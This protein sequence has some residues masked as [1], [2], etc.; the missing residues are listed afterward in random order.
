MKAL[1][2][3]GFIRGVCY[4]WSGDRS[5]VERDMG[6]AKRLALNSTRIWLSRTAFLRS[7]D[8]YVASLVS[9]V[10]TAHSFGLTTMPILWNGNM[11][12]PAILEEERRSECDDYV[13]R[14]VDALKEEEGLL[15]W[16]IMNEP[17]CNDYI[18]KAAGDEQQEREAKLWGFVRH[19]LEYVRSID[20]ENALTVGNTFIGDTGP[21]ADL[22]DV[23]SFHDYLET[24]SR[25][26]ATYLTAESL[27]RTFGKPLV[28]SELA[29][30]CRAN[31][32]DMA[33]EAC[34]R[35]NVGWYLFELMVH[36]Y[37]GDVHGIVYPDGTVRD[38]S[39]VAAIYGFRRNRDRKTSVRPNPNKEGHVY[40]A[41]ELVQSALRQDTT[42][43]RNKSNSTDEILEAAEYCA[44]LLEAAELVPMCEPPTMRI[45]QWRSQPE[46][47]RDV[48]A[49]RV[50][51]YDLAR[52][53]KEKTA[54]L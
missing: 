5:I 6:Y 11:L 28:N 21:T 46:E 42:L 15:M 40:R 9:Y 49:I 17:T 22:V 16:D 43:F 24:R 25:V 53:L 32:Y 35:H 33:L 14:I 51:A 44:N 45:L 7:P 38:P 36:G 2:D 29:C 31:P 18:R 3:Y 20:G 19:N 12:D 34:E 39:I 10:R 23:I 48:D 8:E 30:L 50:F 26:E 4:G 41:V 47:E 52:L 37:W 54:T 1:D 13:R 27:S